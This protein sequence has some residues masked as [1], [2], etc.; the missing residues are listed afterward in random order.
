MYILTCIVFST[1]LRV[2]ENAT[3]LYVLKLTSFLL[4]W[5]VFISFLKCHLQDS[6]SL[7]VRALHLSPFEEIKKDQA[8]HGSEGVNGPYVALSFPPTRVN[9]SHVSPI[10]KALCA[11]ARQDPWLHSASIIG[12]EVTVSRLTQGRDTCLYAMRVSAFMSLL[13]LLTVE[14]IRFEN[15]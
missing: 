14:L 2:K 6:F 12:P 9:P 13:W 11:G 1:F 4:F 15:G 3:S 8:R 5:N 10:R 7:F